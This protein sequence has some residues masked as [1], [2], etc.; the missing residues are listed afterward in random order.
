LGVVSIRREDLKT[1][2]TFGGA[3]I[4]LGGTMFLLSPNGLSAWLNSLPV[5]LGGWLRPSGVPAGRLL[6]ALLAYQPLA[7]SF[8]LVA[9]ARGWLQ[10]RKR[11]MRLSLW[12]LAALLVI[13]FYPARQV[14]DLAWVSIPLWVLAALE[15]SNHTRIF[16]EERREVAGMAA[17]VLILLSFAWLDYAGIAL[18]PLTPANLTSNAIQVGDLAWVL[19]P[20]WMLAALELSN[21]TRIFLEER[22]EVAGM[23]ALVLILISFAWLDYA[24]IALDPLNPANLTS[25]A[26][27]VGGNIL[28]QNLPPTRYVLLISV[29]LLLV[30]SVMM[31]ALGWS[32]RTARLGSV[33]GLTIALGIYSLGMAWGAT[34]LRTPDGWELW[35]SDKRPVQADLLL[36]TVNEQSEWSTGDAMSQDVTLLDI[37]SPALEWLLRG[38]TVHT[39][40]ALDL[41]DAPT[42]VISSQ[43]E[44][45]SLPIAYR[46][47]DFTWRR[48]P[49]WDI[50]GIYEWIKW[51]VFRDMPYES[52]TVIVWVRND[53]FIDTGQSSP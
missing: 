48:E 38:R 21:H 50:A 35:W 40:S 45:L 12:F 41:Q 15:L 36:A 8:G 18:D 49:F 1:A 5:Y 22:R 31:V 25:N 30:V 16:L 33:W 29:L 42:I 7:L 43:T 47:Q 52:E 44:E 17:L 9:V 23:A 13:V 2:L 53:L 14:G 34:G 10:R 19:I 26:I 24:G 6:F 32:A 11:Y 3:T 46:G 27:Q 20:L 39:V 37:D 51:S 4:L 28:F